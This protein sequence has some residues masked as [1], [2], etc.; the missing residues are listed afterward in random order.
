VVLL[1]TR[2]AMVEKIA[3]TL[4]NPV[5]AG[6]GSTGARLARSQGGGGGARSRGAARAATGGVFQ[7]CDP[8]WP[9]EATLSLTLPP[10][11]GQEGAE[12]FRREVAAEL[13]QQEA[14]ACEEVRRQGFRFLG[15]EGVREVSPL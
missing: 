15:A 3:Y 8:E 12:V 7:S 14:Q 13:A 9:E 4:A 1:V 2:A 10:A 5:A 6:L 11:V